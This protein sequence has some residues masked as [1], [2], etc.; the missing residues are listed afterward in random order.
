MVAFRR[1][2]FGNNQWFRADTALKIGNLAD[3]KRIGP[4]LAYQLM[5]FAVKSDFHAIA[6]VRLQTHNTAAIL[7]IARI[8][9][10]RITFPPGRCAAL[11][12]PNIT[13]AEVRRFEIQPD[14]FIGGYG[15]KIV[16]AGAV[17]CRNTRCRAENS[18]QKQIDASSDCAH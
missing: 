18:K 12:E 14:T 7:I 11:P 16:L 5:A 13:L 6:R 4:G 1:A 8:E 17:R 10:E 2:G 3:G 15:V 9:N